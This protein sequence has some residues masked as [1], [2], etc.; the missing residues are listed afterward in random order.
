MKLV[1]ATRNAD[2]VREFNDALKGLSV[3]I[4]PASDFPGAPEVVE[5]AVTLEENALKKARFLSQ[6]TGLP[7]VADDTGLFVEALHG[8]PG[9]RSA[10]YAGP[11]AD[12]RANVDRL[13]SEMRGLKEPYRRAFFRT[14]IAVRTPDAKESILDGEV[15]GHITAARFGTNGFGYD[16]VFLPGGEQRTFAEMTL[17]EKNAISHRGK[18]VAKLREWL[19]SVL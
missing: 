11:K 15:H 10:R 2:K 13:L 14:V 4:L 19:E 8:E 12:Y 9:V 18:A 16:P 6:F 3:E 1:L 5:D 17:E 7:A